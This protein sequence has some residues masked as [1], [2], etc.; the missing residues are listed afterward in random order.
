[1]ALGVAAAVAG[2]PLALK[3]QL[4]G[5]LADPNVDAVPDEL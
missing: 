2:H 4:D 5:V 1:V 3:K